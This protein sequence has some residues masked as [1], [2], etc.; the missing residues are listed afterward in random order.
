MQR[1]RKKEY[2]IG[3]PEE[4]GSVLGIRLV[5]E[6]LSRGCN[7]YVSTIGSPSAPDL[8]LA[9]SDMQQ[10]M[11]SFAKKY[12]DSFQCVEDLSR[13]GALASLGYDGM[14]IVPCPKDLIRQLADGQTDS[15]LTNYARS[16]ILQHRPLVL[17]PRDTPFT[18]EYLEHMLILSKLRVAVVPAMLSFSQKN[19]SYENMI[20]T[21]VEKILDSLNV[22]KN[23]KEGAYE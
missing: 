21:I 13:G 5:A 15:S 22:E 6:L 2:V 11:E 9:L 18:T 16:C 19:I 3:I 4:E 1:T 20:D 10:W 12:P 17:V 23:G 14:V 7:V 8:N